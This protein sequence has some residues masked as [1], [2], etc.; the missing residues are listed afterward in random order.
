MYTSVFTGFLAIYSFLQTKTSENTLIHQHGPKSWY[1]TVY[2]YL[3]SKPLFRHQGKHL[4]PVNWSFIFWVLMFIKVSLNHFMWNW[5]LLAMEPVWWMFHPARDQHSFIY[6]SELC[7]ITQSQ[8]TFNFKQDNFINLQSMWQP[9]QKIM[10]LLFYY[11]FK[12]SP[13]KRCKT[14]ELFL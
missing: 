2:E 4:H 12:W 11:L 14:Q 5:C 7:I 13:C 6:L 8:C 9:I 3:N 10:Q 1:K